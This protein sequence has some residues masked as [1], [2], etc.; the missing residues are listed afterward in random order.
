MA[1]SS[2]TRPELAEDFP[3]NGQTGGKVR[4]D[5]KVVDAWKVT[6]GDKSGNGPLIAIIDSG[7]DLDHPDLVGNLWVNPG[8]I[9]G[10]GID[11]DGNGTSMTSTATT[12]ATTT[13][14]RT[15]W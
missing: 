11:D 4:A 15:T 14:A 13:E 8:E 2:P 5:S 10:N 12:L 9:P 7:A 3:N 6:T 1:T